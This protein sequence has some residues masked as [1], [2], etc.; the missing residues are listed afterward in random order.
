M[1]QNKDLDSVPEDSG[2]YHKSPVFDLP[3]GLWICRKSQK[4]STASDQYFLSY[5]KKKLQGGQIDLSFNKVFV[6]VLLKL[7]VS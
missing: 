3:G 6:Q 1:G 5:V 2:S 4:M 7:K